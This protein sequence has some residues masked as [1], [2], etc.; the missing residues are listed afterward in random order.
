MFRFSTRL[1]LLVGAALVLAAV[2]LRQHFNY[3]ERAI[4]PWLE[5]RYSAWRTTREKAVVQ[6]VLDAQT[7][8]LPPI[9]KVTVYTV[10]DVD[11]AL[12]TGFPIRPYEKFAPIL[13]ETTVTGADA[14]RIAGMWRGM[15]FGGGGALCH[16][17][18]YGLRFYNGD[19][20]LCETSLCWVCWNCFVRSE[21][22]GFRW[23]GFGDED[24]RFLDHLQSIVPLPITTQAYIARQR[25]A[26]HLLAQEYPQAQT[27][28][29]H[30]ERLEPGNWKTDETRGR[31]HQYRGDYPRAI[32]AFTRAIEL[33][34]DAG[35]LYFERGLLRASLG[36]RQGAIADYGK[37]IE[38]QEELQTEYVHESRGLLYVD[39]GE[40]EKALADFAIG[41]FPASPRYFVT[42]LQKTAAELRERERGNSARYTIRGR[43]DL[44]R[45]C[46]DKLEKYLETHGPLWPMSPDARYKLLTRPDSEDRLDVVVRDANGRE[47]W[48]AESGTKASE[49]W[50]IAWGKDNWIWFA[51][52]GGSWQ[53]K[54]AGD[55]QWTYAF[56][57]GLEAEPPPEIERFYAPY[58]Q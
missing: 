55:G 58:Q 53:W 40:F 39:A 21:D 9:D 56:E 14:Q 12:T 26:A 47:I 54:P 35:S 11:D 1:K 16:Y 42:Y 6:S 45:R 7:T 5:T 31:F 8:K 22:E 13:R 4:L 34:P 25:A 41:I 33:R 23:L 24:Q 37:A 2:H 32:E 36:D 38:H 29:D 18:I 28:L 17:P 49:R 51:G 57:P 52:L 10:G 15:E 43:A 50:T 44:Y 27:E 20:L 48:R 30:A 19:K 46:A 3:P